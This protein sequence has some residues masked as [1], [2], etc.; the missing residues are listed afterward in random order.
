MMTA[1]YAS[2]G[3]TGPDA[4]GTALLAAA[5]VV[6]ALVGVQLAGPS[7]RSVAPSAPHGR[8]GIQRRRQHAA[9]VLVGGADQHAERRSP[10]IDCDM[11]FAPRPAAV[12]GAGAGRNTPLFAC[13]DAL[14][15]AARRQSSCPATCRRSSSTWCKDAQTPASCQSRRRRQ[16]LMPEPQPISAGS[17]SHGRPD[18]STNRMPVSAARAGTGGR[19]PRGRA[20]TGGSRGSMIDHKASGRRGAGRPPHHPV[21]V[22]VQGF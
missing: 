21:N 16:Q 12:R 5:P 11:T 20:G 4:T 15:R 6:V 19:P 9:V 14:S 17:I 1:V 8:N 10:G 22:R 7:S 13:T 18:L 2:P 3:D